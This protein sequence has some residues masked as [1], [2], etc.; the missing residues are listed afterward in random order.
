MLMLVLD[1]GLIVCIGLLVG[2][3]FAV[4][5]FINP[6]LWR[7]ES[8]AQAAAIRM[9]ATR[10]GKSMPF[11]YGASLLLL[12]AETF[13]RHH[14]RGSSLLIAASA[15]WT[16]VILLTIAFLV[17]INNRMMQ[18]DT[19]AFPE[20]AKRAHHRWDTLHRIRVLALTT[21]MVF[22]LLAIFTVR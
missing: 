10:L 3:E 14:E 7:M 15:I 13:L 2:T 17:P 21:A 19:G 12:L 20:Q 18:L 16:A 4:S 9:F 5:V 1:I 22:A 11:W 8:S 6:V